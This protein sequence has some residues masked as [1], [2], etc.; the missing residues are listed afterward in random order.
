MPLHDASVVAV[1][2]SGVFHWE[3]TPFSGRRASKISR[4]PHDA[5]VG[6]PEYKRS[7]K[8]KDPVEAKRLRAVKLAELEFPLG[9][10]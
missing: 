3:A 4:T 8:T 2:G 6:K 7:L 1:T 5:I 10:P 9:V